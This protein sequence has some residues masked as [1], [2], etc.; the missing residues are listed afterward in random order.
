MERGKGGKPPRGTK[1][2]EVTKLIAY[3]DRDRALEAVGLSE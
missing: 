1:S 2:E 3:W